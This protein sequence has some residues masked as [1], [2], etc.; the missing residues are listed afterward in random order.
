MADIVLKDR[1]GEDVTYS[2]IETVTFDTPTEGEQATFTFGVEM[3]GVEVPLSM[4][5]GDQQLAVPDGYLVK[6]ATIKKPET[7]VPENI[8]NGTTVAG[9]VGEFIG[10]TEE[11]A[12][13]L[14]MADGDQTVLPSADGKVLS[15]VV[16]T[17]PETLIPENIAKDVE[18]GGVVGT[19][20]GGGGN[21]IITEMFS[22][23]VNV[24][25]T[26]TSSSG[27]CI[28]LSAADLPDWWPAYGTNIERVCSGKSSVLYF[29]VVSFVS[30]STGSNYLQVATL[31]NASGND[32]S[33]WT[34]VSGRFGSGTTQTYTGYLIS[35]NNPGTAGIYQNTSG[36]CVYSNASY[37]TTICLVK[38]D[39]RVTLMKIITGS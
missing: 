18:I 23:V 34:G 33:P 2:G 19:H 26:A 32:S 16:I 25:R 36:L 11:T 22:T 37:N 9:V 39:Y 12:V 14:Y 21:E 24:N 13:E 5:D 6:A 28:L 8:R 1:D 3:T 10:D 35:N 7:L 29:A 30:G 4:A 31:C 27:Y 15:K 17:K 38:G 20:E